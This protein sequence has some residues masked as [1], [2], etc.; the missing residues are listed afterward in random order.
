MRGRH[1][2]S[3]IYNTYVTKIVIFC[4]D[5]TDYKIHTTATIFFYQPDKTSESN[6]INSNCAH[7][8][9]HE[10]YQ[11]MFLECT[12]YNNIVCFF[13]IKQTD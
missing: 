4:C 11:P 5:A 1:R 3:Y 8:K 10:R 2:L 7:L 12:V 6:L 9:L 13:A